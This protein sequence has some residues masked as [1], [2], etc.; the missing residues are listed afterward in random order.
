[1]RQRSKGD[2]KRRRDCS[3]EKLQL[4]STV[5]QLIVKVTEWVK[6]NKEN[7]GRRLGRGCQSSGICKVKV[8][9][10]AGL[11]GFHSSLESRQVDRKCT[12]TWITGSRRSVERNIFCS[13]VF[14]SASIT[15]VW[16][17]IVLGS[18]GAVTI[19]KRKKII[20]I[21]SCAWDWWAKSTWITMTPQRG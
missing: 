13:Y 20:R 16:E 15:Y 14:L 21:C 19:W 10:T 17:A 8:D 7:I 1:M 6:E 5:K 4:R 18:A 9:G 11:Y 3:L 12:K 2:G